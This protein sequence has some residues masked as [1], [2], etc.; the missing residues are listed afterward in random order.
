MSA[1][2]QMGLGTK[3]PRLDAGVFVL[4]LNHS[5]LRQI[6]RSTNYALRRKGENYGAR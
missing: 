3:E 1:A 6:S 2:R 5:G 4:E